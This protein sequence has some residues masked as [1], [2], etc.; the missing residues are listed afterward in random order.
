[1]T[2]SIVREQWVETNVRSTLAAGTWERREVP[3][4]EWTVQTTAAGVSL[5]IPLRDGGC[6]IL[7]AVA[8]DEQGRP[9]RTEVTFYAL[10]PGPSF[11]RSNGNRIELTPERTNVEAR[12]DGARARAVAVAARHRARHRRARRHSQP[13]ACRDH[14]RRR[15]PSTCRSPT[16]TCRTCTS[17][18]CSSKDARRP[19]SAADQSRS[20]PARS[21]A[22]ATPSSRSTT[23]RSGLNVDVTA[24]RE[25]YR[26]RQEVRVSVAVAEQT[27]APGA[28]AASREIT[29]WAM[30]YGLLSLTE[31]QDARC[32]A[33]DL[34]AESAAGDDA[35]TIAPRLHHSP[36][37]GDQAQTLGFSRGRRWWRPRGRCVSGLGVAGGVPMP[38]APPP[39]PQAM[40]AESV[41]GRGGKSGRSRAGCDSQRLPTA[42]LLARIGRDRRRT[43]ARRRP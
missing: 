28:S 38:A 13:S 24:D 32:R 29:L 43:A 11:W 26:P 2:V 37:R 33:R 10:G 17:R 1:M 35:R 8:R 7:R 19:T 16:P 39:P 18:C 42:R 23:P 6:Y 40:L 31:L 34:R 22:S 41:H 30:D 21:S 25:E 4:G 14:V 15:T 5:P 27:A 36:A 12:R 9:T 3:V 20:G